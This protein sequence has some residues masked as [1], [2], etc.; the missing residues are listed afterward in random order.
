MET[1]ITN[2]IKVKSRYA[3][4]LSTFDM[5]LQTA[6]DDALQRYLVEQIRIKIKAL[7][8]KDQ[9][10]QKKYGKDYN[11]FCRLVAEDENYVEQIEKDITKLWESDLSEWE[12]CHEGIKDWTEQLQNIL[13]ML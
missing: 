5:D 13:I 6:V 8:K 11:L 9:A 4:L 3:Q 7:K 12:F 2:S 10:F 1:G